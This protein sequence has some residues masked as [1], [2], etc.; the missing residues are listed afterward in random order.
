MVF[1][2]NS[3]DRRKSSLSPDTIK[4]LREAK[5]D[6]AKE[7]RLELRI[8]VDRSIVEVFANKQWCLTSRVYPENNSSLNVCLFS[9]QGETI[10]NEVRCWQMER[11]WP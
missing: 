7:E 9:K 6:L 1:L 2:Y 8:F 11:I 10:F 3:N 5:I 4:D